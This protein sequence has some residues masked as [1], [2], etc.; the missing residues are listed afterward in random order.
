M[1]KKEE[2][3]QAKRAITIVAKRNDIPEEQI[4]SD[5]QEAIRISF[6]STDPHVQAQLAACGFVGS[7]PTPEEFIT[8]VSKK[9]N[10]RLDK[11]FT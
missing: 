10:A 4:R 2:L 7:E 6:S 5:L 9:V 1:Y 8:W 3:N 11:R